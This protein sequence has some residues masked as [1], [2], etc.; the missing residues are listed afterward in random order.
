MSASLKKEPCYNRKTFETWESLARDESGISAFLQVQDF[1]SSK[2][3]PILSAYHIFMLT[4]PTQKT[5]YN[6]KDKL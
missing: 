3:S 1:Q 4:L 2:N 6:I 5:P